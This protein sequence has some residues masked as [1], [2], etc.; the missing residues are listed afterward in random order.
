MRVMASGL[1]QL[2]LLGV[3]VSALATQAQLPYATSLPTTVASLQQE[4]DDDVEHVPVLNNIYFSSDDMIIVPGRTRA[5]T[6]SGWN[7]SADAP[8]CL[9]AA[10][11]GKDRSLIVVLLL[12]TMM[13]IPTL[14]PS[15]TKQARVLQ[16]R[17]CASKPA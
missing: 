15:N 3:V 17:V 9:G 10:D 1:L 7:D 16:V 11:A 5:L 8:F 6:I 2:L 14:I 12:M 4:I 13:I